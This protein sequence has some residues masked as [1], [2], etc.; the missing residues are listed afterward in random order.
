MGGL[1]IV[2]PIV[3]FDLW[4]SLTTGRRQIRRWLELR[5]WRPMA[6]AFAF[7][8]VTAVL[9]TFVIK[10]TWSGKTKVIGIPIPLT[11]FHLEDNNIWTHT[12]L[13]GP[14]P[15]I[16]LFTDILTGLA[17]PFI[18]YKVAEFIKAVK[19]EMK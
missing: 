17:A 15:Y 7:G 18:P 2:I 16:A 5:Q 11:F 12:G 19:A 10:Y 13:P 9:I 6:L 3:A 8:I 1:I 4:L 14:M